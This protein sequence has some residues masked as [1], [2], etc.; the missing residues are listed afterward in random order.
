MDPDELN[1]LD[2]FDLFDTEAQRIDRYFATLDED[3]WRRPSRCK[4]WSV[5][6]VVA[7]LAGQ[8]AYNLAC[9][10]GNVRELFDRLARQ[11]SPRDYNGFNE[12]CVQQRRGLP[13]AE[14]LAEYLE[15]N[16]QTRRRMRELGRDG[17]LD[18]SVGPYPNGLQAF[19]YASEFATHADDVGAP[20]GAGEEPGRTAWRARVGQ[21]VLSEQ[22]RPVA[23]TP[24]PQGFQVRSDGLTAELPAPD[25]VEA[26]VARLPDEYPLHPWL[27]T[28]LAC[29]A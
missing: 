27:R 23:V 6:D 19:H 24:M 25:F 21:F 28:V 29:L 9:L 15:L 18:T 14:V 10:D 22:D 2:P 5:Q 4:G 7:H 16:G 26:T 20:V 13:A 8:E 11:G 1:D 3:A 12:W 17:V